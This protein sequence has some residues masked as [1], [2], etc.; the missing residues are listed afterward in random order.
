MY[1]N[2]LQYFSAIFQVEELI[3]DLP[4]LTV[5]DEF[6]L[7]ACGFYCQSQCHY[8]FPT[9]ILNRWSSCLSPTVMNI[10]INDTMDV[11]EPDANSTQYVMVSS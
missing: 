5:F 4:P 1:A 8:G 2:L 7:K 3:A 11:L 6:R 10:T 9:L